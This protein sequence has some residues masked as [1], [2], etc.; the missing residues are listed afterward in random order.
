MFVAIMASASL[1]CL[2]AP[3]MELGVR[4]PER[5]VAPGIAVQK[6]AMKKIEWLAGDWEGTAKFDT[7][8]GGGE[9]AWM[10][11]RQSEAVRMKLAGRVMLIEGT[12]R[13]KA[14]EEDRIVFEALATIAF[15][16]EK[17]EYTM[18]AFGPE[19]AVDPK[20]E[21][22]D[23]SIVWGFTTRLGKMRYTITLDD[24]GRWVEVGHRSNDDGKTWIKFIDMVLERK[25]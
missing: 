18:R 16:A 1:M 8:R 17:K 20:L 7:G 5:A 10:S 13:V 19:G 4:Q 9:E 3:S 12:G 24:Q 6:E 25:K 14:G 15:D 23:K 2:P 22:G 11:I 21:V